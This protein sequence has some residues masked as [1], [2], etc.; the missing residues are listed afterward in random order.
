[1]TKLLAG[2]NWIFLFSFTHFPVKKVFLS[3][4]AQGTTYHITYYASDSL[5]TKSQI[6]SI[7]NRIDSSL[8]LYKPYSLINQFNN[9][10]DGI[11][12][13]EHFEKVFSKAI[14][15]YNQ[16]NGLF[17]ITIFPITEA[18][19]FGPVKNTSIP[20]TAAIRGLL[21]CVGSKLLYWQGKKLVKKKTCVKLDANGIA[22]GYSVDVIAAFLEQH[23]IDN[24]MAELGGE[25]RV[26]G[27]KIPGN[28]RMSIG[29]E[30][31]GDDLVAPVM[32]K[33][34]WL[35]EGALTTSGNYRRYYESNGRRISHLLDPHT[36]F[37]IQNELISVTVFAKD[38]MTADAYDNALMGMGLQQ[39]MKFV[40]GRPDLAAY[41]IYRNVNGAVADTMSSRFH[42]LEK[43]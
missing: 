18:W 15:T 14:D 25:L 38:A 34:I 40:E 1:M 22:Q 35:D 29:I 24:Y 4:S 42:S 32:E 2:I 7:L 41:F 37:P 5:V 16:T 9:S 31:P 8:S 43:H 27:R 6:D 3:G 17:D 39:A 13:D 26:K 23:N 30:A 11:V 19:G 33:T 28:E 36:G 12:V 20:D 21:P 10:T